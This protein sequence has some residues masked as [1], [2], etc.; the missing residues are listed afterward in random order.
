LIPKPSFETG[1]KVLKAVLAIAFLISGALGSYILAT[2]SYLWAQAPTHADGLVAFVVLDL[3]A[4]AG[5]YALPGITRIVALLLP[6]V[7]LAAMAGDLYM[8]LGSP[9]SVIQGAFHEYLLNDSAFMILLV[10]QAVLAG[11]AFGNLLQHH[12][13]P[14]AGRRG[15]RMGS[16]TAR[17]DRRAISRAL[18]AA[19]VVVVVIVAGVGIYFATSSNA[20]SVS[21]SSTQYSGPPAL[22][23]SI[24]SGAA[25]SA[26][27]P[28]YTPD[29]ITLVMGVNNTVTWTNNDSIHHTVTST[30]APSGGSFS[31]GNMNGGG[32]TY[33]HT[34]TVPGTYQYDCEYHSWMT[35]TI[36]VKA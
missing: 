6:V 1:A 25:N 12:P 14:R 31:S 8:G 16:V 21:T 5:I 10:L 19:V 30:S 27:P 28:G 23:V 36:V 22:Q 9:G 26:N 11:L 18:I 20:A 24:Y 13:D 34:F 35:G 4:V 17:A 32:A 7:Q 33:T 29:S 2:D 15:L 3:V